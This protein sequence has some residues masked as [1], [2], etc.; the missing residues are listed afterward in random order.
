VNPRLAHL[1]EAHRLAVAAFVVN[2]REARH[3][4]SVLRTPQV[5]AEWRR[6]R[7]YDLRLQIATLRALRAAITMHCLGIKLHTRGPT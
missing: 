7:Y 4:T 1:E 3:F 5:R 6:D 2:L